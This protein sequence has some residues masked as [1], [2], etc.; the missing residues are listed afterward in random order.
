MA[1]EEYLTE[2][3]PKNGWRKVAYV[4]FVTEHLHLCSAAMLFAELAQQKSKAERVLLYPKGWDRREDRNQEPLNPYVETSRRLLGAA[5][6]R[7]GV[8]LRA[9]EP[10]G[11]EG[12][13]SVSSTKVAVLKRGLHIEILPSTYPLAEL[14][15]LTNY[16]RILYLQTPGLLLNSTK[17][18]HL[19]ATSS[20]NLRTDESTKPPTSRDATSILLLAPSEAAFTQAHDRLGA[21]QAPD[22]E[23]LTRPLSERNLITP[24]SDDNRLVL[25]SSHMKT[26]PQESS[27]M[28]STS[29]AS[30]LHFSDPALPGPEYDIP[31]DLFSRQ[32]PRDGPTRRLWERSYEKFRDLR[33]EVCGLDLEP[34]P[35]RAGKPPD[36]LDTKGRE[37]V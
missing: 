9:M 26:E 6:G 32:A 3:R 2:T 8:V 14:L 13:T 36:V 33:M 22:N 28:I 34:M 10:H 24:P 25:E 1:Y 11:A 12:R 17:L 18:D 21:E 23:L 15:A 20:K 7:Y 29:S 4:Q 5:S 31:R 35:M 19:L 16:D 37:G 30:Y 27:A